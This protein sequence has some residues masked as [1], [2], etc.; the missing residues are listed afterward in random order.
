MRTIED[1]LARLRVASDRPGR[2]ALLELGLADGYDLFESAIGAV[3]VAFNPVGVSA[4]D[5]AE[6]GAEARL[7]ARFGRPFFPARAPGS[8]RDLITRA[9]EWGTPGDLPLD[10]RS[11]TAFQRQVLVETAA[12]PRGEVRSYGRIAADVGRPR[13][14]RAVGST[15]AANPIP[16]IVPCHRVVR[17]DGTLGHYSLGGPDRKAQLLHAEGVDLEA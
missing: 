2:G 15:M 3:A 10:L 14:F 17:S 16:L 11:V 13:A 6:E 8:W 9:I 12:I 1:D 5:L 7:T 4:V